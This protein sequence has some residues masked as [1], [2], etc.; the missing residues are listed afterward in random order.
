MLK[1]FNGADAFA[2]EILEKVV[3]QSWVFDEMK[4]ISNCDLSLFYFYLLVY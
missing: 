4:A 3:M 2:H 1:I